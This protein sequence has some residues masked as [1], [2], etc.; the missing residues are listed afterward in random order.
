MDEFERQVGRFVYATNA[1]FKVV[2][3]EEFLKLMEMMRPGIKIPA[4]RAVAGRILQDVHDEEWQKFVA[5]VKEKLCTL[6]IDGWS[7]LTSNPVLAICLGQ[8][9]ITSIDTTGVVHYIFLRI[10]TYP[11][12]RQPTHW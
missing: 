11:R 8:Q 4:R 5:S 7:T 6:Q 1:P 3:N 12:L 9:I 2:E 10:K